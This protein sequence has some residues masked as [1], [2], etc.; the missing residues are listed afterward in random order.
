MATAPRNK[1]KE[2]PDEMVLHILNFA[3]TDARTMMRVTQVC[4]RWHACVA[5][6]ALYCANARAKACVREWC[7]ILGI[8]R[9][10]KLHSTLL[11]RLLAFAPSIHPNDFHAT[12][13][14]WSQ[15]MQFIVSGAQSAFTVLHMVVPEQVVFAH[16]PTWHHAAAFAAELLA[17]AGGQWDTDAPPHSGQG[18]YH[19]QPYQVAATHADVIFWRAAAAATGARSSCHHDRLA[20]KHQVGLRWHTPRTHTPRACWFFLA[21]RQVRL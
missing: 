5:N 11:L 2:L 14:R 15:F 19:V 20:L 17:I 12:C 16:E 6:C 7:H 21:A 13:S 10:V 3:C 18:G 8:A 9:P 4:R 1:W